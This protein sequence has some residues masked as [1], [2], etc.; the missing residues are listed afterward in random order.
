M[1]FYCIVFRL[2]SICL[3]INKMK[4]FIFTLVARN[5]PPVEFTTVNRTAIRA[6]WKLKEDQNDITGF[7]LVYIPIRY[8]DYWHEA[9]MISLPPTANEYIISGLNPEKDYRIELRMISGPVL[10]KPSIVVYTRQRRKPIPGNLKL[11]DVSNPRELKCVAKGKKSLF[12]S[13]EKPLKNGDIGDYSVI[14]VAGGKKIK[15][16]TPFRTRNLD[17]VLKD[18]QPGTWY[19]IKVD[20]KPRR[21]RIAKVQEQL[22][23]AVTTKFESNVVACKTAEA[24][25]WIS[26]LAIV[27]LSESEKDIHLFK[28]WWMMKDW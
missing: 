3:V 19:Y 21:D 22:K 9:R 16:Y 10:S 28:A 27:L 1:G 4:L 24:G 14:I 6:H 18:L 8:A 12:L 7:K 17:Y 2:G 23:R 25:M 13:W 11:L 15:D 20:A 5:G 26:I